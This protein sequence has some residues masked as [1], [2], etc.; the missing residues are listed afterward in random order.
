MAIQRKTSTGPV[1]ISLLKRREA[2]AWVDIGLPARAFRRSA[3]SWVDLLPTGA[4]GGL[5]ATASTN[6]V[7]GAYNCIGTSCATVRSVTSSP[8]V[9]T[10]TG[11]S[12][13]GPTYSWARVSGDSAISATASTSG[14]T[15]FTAN[16]P[17]ETE[18]TAVFRCTV[19]RGIDTVT[20]DVNVSIS[21]AWGI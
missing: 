8:V 7:V 2:G 20:V 3:G 10:A 11:G 9:I 15:Q 18:Y 13:P 14:T 12:G 17:R 16:V 5:S 4:S 1:D 21:Y 6:Y 19:T